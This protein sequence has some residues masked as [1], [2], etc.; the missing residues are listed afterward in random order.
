[1]GE[2]K[3]LLPEAAPEK[4]LEKLKEYRKKGSSTV[5]RKTQYFMTNA[6]A[7][8]FAALRQEKL[9]IGSGSI[10]SAVRRIVNLRIKGAGIF[11]KIENVEQ[12]MH[13]RCQFKSGNCNTFYNE[14]SN[15]EKINC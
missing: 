1:M 5:R 6:Y 12:F 7:I 2:M 10:E 11:W 8:R 15:C 3:T 13:L 14:L 4:F 9:P